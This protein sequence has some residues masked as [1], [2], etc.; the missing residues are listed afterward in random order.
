M[1]AFTKLAN[2]LFVNFFMISVME[3]YPNRTTILKVKFSIVERW[4]YEYNL[5]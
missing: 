4:V 2:T 3:Y 1:V 5:Y